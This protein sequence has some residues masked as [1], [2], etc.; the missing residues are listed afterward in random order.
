M[1]RLLHYGLHLDFEKILGKVIH[2]D[3]CVDKPFCEGLTWLE[4]EERD[5][6]GFT[7]CV[8]LW[9]GLHKI[10]LTF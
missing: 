1:L 3:V 8:D 5:Y 6:L 7:A 4:I 9:M 10:D 2:G